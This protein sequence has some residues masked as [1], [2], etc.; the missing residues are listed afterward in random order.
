[1]ALNDLL[2]ADVPLRNNSL[3]R[4]EIADY[5]FSEFIHSVKCHHLLRQPVVKVP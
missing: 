4:T 5:I 1:M 2:F 3:T